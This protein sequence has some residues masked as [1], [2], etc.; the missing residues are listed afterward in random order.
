MLKC[1]E[2]AELANDYVD[3]ELPW[4]QSM[5]MSLHLSMCKHCAG[6]VKKLRLVITLAKENPPESLSDE[7]AEEIVQNVLEK[8][9]KS[10]NK[11]D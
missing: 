8:N 11:G 6:F 9:T 7:N 3:K 1:R 4:H 10:T 2:V 5:A